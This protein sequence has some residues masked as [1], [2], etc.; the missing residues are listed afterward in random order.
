MSSEQR[1]FPKITDEALDAATEGVRRL[2]EFRKRLV[3]AAGDAGGAAGAG[4]AAAEELRGAFTAALDDDLS[5]PQALAAVFTF[6]R[7]VNRE[8]D[9]SG[10]SQAG[11]RGLLAAFD[12]AMG[13]LDVLPTA[14]EVDAGLAAWVE[15]RIR[16]R[17]AARKA[18][19]F[20][21]A[22][23]IRA[24]I[25]ARGVELED[26]PGGTRWKKR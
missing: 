8:L 25:L 14:A 4:G 6:V 16:D 2:G 10:L 23:A 17:Q 26:A 20:A 12:R 11:A 18:R 15:A 19:D 7:V 5:S 24:E 9:G 22:D 1:L 21:R 13:V 3:E